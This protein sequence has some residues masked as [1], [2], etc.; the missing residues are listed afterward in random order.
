MLPRIFELFAQADRSLARS[1]GGLGI[2]LTLVQELA[3][4]HGG[5]VTATSEGPGKGSEFVLRLP[6]AE[7]PAAAAGGSP[8][9]ARGGGVATRLEVLV[10]DDNVDTADGHGQAPEALG[11]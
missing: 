5:T 6:V 4:L 3:E 8:Q 1:E 10:V 2:G 9:A 7:A 11:P